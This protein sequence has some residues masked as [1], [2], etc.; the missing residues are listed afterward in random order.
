MNRNILG[1]SVEIIA[2]KVWK[3]LHNYGKKLTGLRSPARSYFSNSI[4]ARYA[5]EFFAGSEQP[6]EKAGYELIDD[7]QF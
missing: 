6:I 3:R 2:G 1:R 5:K 7:R 4:I